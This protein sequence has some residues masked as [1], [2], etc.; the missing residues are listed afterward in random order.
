MHWNMFPMFLLLNKKRIWW[1]KCRKYIRSSKW[2]NLNNGSWKDIRKVIETLNNGEKGEYIGIFTTISYRLREVRAKVPEL[3]D[4]WG[5][6]LSEESKIYKTCSNVFAVC[7]SFPRLWFQF[8][9]PWVTVM[10]P[11]KY[12]SK[13]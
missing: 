6:K 4:L 3:N 5:V 10:I 12:I 9:E 7:F 11:V 13:L 2:Y 1:E 8:L